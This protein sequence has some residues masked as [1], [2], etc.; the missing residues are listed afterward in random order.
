VDGEEKETVRT[1]KLATSIVALNEK[2]VQISA[3]KSV[4]RINQGLGSP[5]TLVLTESGVALNS[6]GGGTKGQL[7]VMLVEGQKGRSTPDRVDIDGLA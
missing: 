6:F 1:P 2:V 7:G 3:T 5:H 4:D